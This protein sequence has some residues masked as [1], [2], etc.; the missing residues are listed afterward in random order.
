LLW[1]D[2]DRQR[3][4]AALRTTLSALRKA[5]GGEWVQTEGDTVSLADGFTCDLYQFQQQLAIA[6]E[7]DLADER[8]VEALKTAVSLYHDTF[9]AGFTLADTVTFDDWQ[10]NQTEAY[11][12][13]IADAL[14]DLCQILTK[15]H[16][17]EPALP[18]AQQWVALDSL[19]E[20][21][22]RQFMLAL[23]SGGYISSAIRHFRRFKQRL[24]DELDI[25][26]E[27]ETLD[28]YDRIRAEK[29]VQSSSTAVSAHHSL[30]PF[31][32]RQAEI[33]TINAWLADPNGRLLT[34]I[35]VGGAGKTRL[36]LE[37]ARLG[38][39][40]SVFVPLA[41]VTDPEFLIGAIAQALNFSFYG[42]G[43][44]QTQLIEYLREKTL[45]LVL[46]NLEQLLPGS[47]QLLDILLNAPGIKILATSR[48]RLYLRGEQIIEVGG[49]P[50]PVQI[51]S[52]PSGVTSLD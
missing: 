50:Y 42:Q 39:R 31:I 19:H 41:P 34:L 48:E 25:L 52:K 32:G 10:L 23:A 9:M 4:L 51:T 36:A 14:R 43:T 21:A 13:K 15:Q 40:P 17:W 1:P 45:L 30:L 11:Q 16:Q 5:L 27:P 6:N 35:G 20:P 37:V 29:P 12:H 3:G 38:K 49:L 46:D 22:I 33:A 7:P 8:R 24:R 26:P 2:L 28:L 47:P 18:Y 44:P